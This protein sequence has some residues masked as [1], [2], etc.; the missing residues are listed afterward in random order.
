MTGP[1]PALSPELDILAF[2]ADVFGGQILLETP[3]IWNFSAHTNSATLRVEN[4]ELA[5]IVALQQNQDIEAQG[6]IQGT[7]PIALSDGRLAV[8]KGYLNAL[9]PGGTIRYNSSDT[10]R[11][12][13]NNKQLGL[14]MDLLSDFRYE[15][16]KSEVDLDDQGNLVLGLSLGGR[17]PGHHGGQE[18]R[19]NIMVEQNLDPLLQSLRLSDTLSHSIENRLR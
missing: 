4:W 16:L 11:N 8:S 7:L 15:I 3:T 1:T 12:L 2:S 5:Q 18:V 17:N 6:T 13:G 19:F 9:P 14:A 10:A